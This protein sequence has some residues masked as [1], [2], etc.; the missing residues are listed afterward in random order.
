MSAGSTHRLIVHCVGPVPAAFPV[1]LFSASVLPVDSY[2]GIPSRTR[3]EPPF[4]DIFWVPTSLLEMVSQYC[5]FPVWQSPLM[6]GIFLQQ[7][8]WVPS[9]CSLPI[10]KQC[11]QS[12]DANSFVFFCSSA[13]CLQICHTATSTISTVPS[14]VLVKEPKDA[15]VS[16][17]LLWGWENRKER[18]NSPNSF[19]PIE[20]DWIQCIFRNVQWE[21]RASGRSYHTVQASSDRRCM[22]SAWQPRQCG[23]TSVLTWLGWNHW[24]VF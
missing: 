10:P 12:N 7:E 20:A 16:W 8:G 17:A 21:Q 24:T 14:S 3:R 6:R 9:N 15:D 23:T 2:P 11:T 22:M 1:R 13:K 4:P 18:E 19:P 5:A